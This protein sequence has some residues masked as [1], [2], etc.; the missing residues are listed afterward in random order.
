ML[1]KS[2]G[3]LLIACLFA[4]IIVFAAGA[5]NYS[6]QT[7]TV[8]TVGIGPNDASLA[9]DSSGY[10]HIS[11][12]D[13]NKSGLKYAWW[14]STSWSI[15]V[16][17][18]GGLT[19]QNG[20]A[21][22]LKLDSKG[23]PH[24]SYFDVD[25]TYHL[26]LRYAYWD[27]KTWVC[28]TID[29]TGGGRHAS[30][31][32]D[33]HGFPHITYYGSSSLK[34]ASWNGTVWTTQIID[35]GVMYNVSIGYYSSLQIDSH[36]N[37]QVSYDDKTNGLMKYASWDGSQWNIQTVDS[38]DTRTSDTDNSLAID[39]HDSPH[40]SYLFNSNLKYAQRTSSGWNVQTVDT[41][42]DPIASVGVSP[43]IGLDS[44][45]TPHI[46]YI[47]QYRGGLLKYAYINNSTWRIYGLTNGLHGGYTTSLAVGANDTVYIV[48]GDSTSHI[49]EYM[50]FNPATLP[51]PIQV[52]NPPPSPT[53]NPTSK[54]EPAQPTPTT[55]PSWTRI[56]TS[57]DISCR[58]TAS[59]TGYT[60]RLEGVLMGNGSGIPNSY[61]ML[62]LSQDG[63]V[64]SNLPSAKTNGTGYFSTTWNLPA[65]GTYLVNATYIGNM[66]FE[67]TSEIVNFAVTP[68]ENE[69]VLSITSNS[70]VSSV[71][72]NSTSM[73]F[74]F[75]V[76]GTNGTTGFT[77]LYVNKS[78]V[79]NVD[80]ITVYLDG[81][82]VPYTTMSVGDSWLV[83]FTY[84][85]SS[86]HVS[87]QLEPHA[88]LSSN[89]QFGYWIIAV[90]IAIVIATCTGVSLI[91]RSKQ[92]S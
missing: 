74:S 27:G 34:Y 61:I 53:P 41:T 19:G 80:S 58:S 31:A 35:P 76:E 83:S 85:H 63:Q 24:I 20:L 69:N 3:L 57:I 28:Q 68:I 67:P 73:Q 43:S 65:V 13:G 70:T 87:I 77:N 40:I 5:V 84:H 14:N 60:A 91:F 56:K 82:K 48:H 30:L 9:L 62:Y 38:G 39:S 54:L 50:F 75:E 29:P 71:S 44:K 7:Q 33:S 22:T 42:G 8:S 72:F 4:S 86:H 12:N 47:D 64:W 89:S 18:D 46:S 66:A 36:D 88:A 16:V 10:P 26:Y 25:S 37:P 11:Y 81:D 21:S 17:E 79:T 45:D 78:L 49:I 55:Q 92:T 51:Q 32:L 2:L 52:P 6:I 15:Q 23:N 59:I 90:L 1:K